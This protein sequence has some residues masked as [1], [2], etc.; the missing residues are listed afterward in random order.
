[1]AFSIL[2][3]I[4]SHSWYQG[5]FLPLRSGQWLLTEL[6]ARVDRHVRGS[7]MWKPLAPRLRSAL[8][9]VAERMLYSKIH[10]I[11][12]LVAMFSKPRQVTKL[13]T[14]DA[15]SPRCFL[16]GGSQGAHIF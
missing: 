3:R 14:E 5:L 15:F 8:P 9:L 4:Q 10:L 11:V 1:M 13:R 16:A 2:R 6:A 12:V 7:S